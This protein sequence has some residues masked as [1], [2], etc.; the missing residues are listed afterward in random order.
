M[1]M[2]NL[3][4]TEANAGM[5]A[6]KNNATSIL[7]N[8]R[9]YRKFSMYVNLFT[10]TNHLRDKQGKSRKPGIGLALFKQMY[11]LLSP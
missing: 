9:L 6:E 4:P 5:R 1:G 10:N 2:L 7:A 8:S 3:S 11:H